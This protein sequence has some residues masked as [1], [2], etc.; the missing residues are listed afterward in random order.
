MGGSILLEQSSYQPLW[1]C[2]RRCSYN[3]HSLFPLYVHGIYEKRT[4]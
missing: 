3:R 2:R 1:E 4:S